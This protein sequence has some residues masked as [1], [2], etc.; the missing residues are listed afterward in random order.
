MKDQTLYIK[1]AIEV[2]ERI[3]SRLQ[4]VDEQEFRSN[5]DLR[6]SIVLQIIYLG[7]ALGRTN[8]DFRDQHPNIPWFEAIGMRHRLA[9]DYGN[10]DINQVWLTTQ[11]DLPELLKQL[12]MANNT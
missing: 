4:G 8:Q 7:E 3:S 10:V 6:D 5:N 12:K 9:H 2:I 11:E 1:D